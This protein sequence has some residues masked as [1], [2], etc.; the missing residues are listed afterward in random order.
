MTVQKMSVHI[1]TMTVFLISNTSYFHIAAESH[2]P[3]CDHRLQ[4]IEDVDCHASLI[5]FLL[6]LMLFK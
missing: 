3:C 5:T 1:K 6:H 4:K 2:R